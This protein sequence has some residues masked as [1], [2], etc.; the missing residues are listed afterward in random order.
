MFTKKIF[1]LNFKAVVTK[2]VTAR[3]KKTEPDTFGLNATRSPLAENETTNYV[4]GI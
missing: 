1:D 4:S 3:S 2:H